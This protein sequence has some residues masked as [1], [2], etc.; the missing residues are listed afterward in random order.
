M[1]QLKE[2]RVLSYFLSFFLLSLKFSFSLNQVGS[3]SLQTVLLDRVPLKMYLLDM[4]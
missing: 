1:S 2:I 4:V 3:S